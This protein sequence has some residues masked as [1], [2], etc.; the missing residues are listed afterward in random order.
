MS[1]ARPLVELW[2]CSSVIL[3]A[4]TNSGIF[5]TNQTG[6]VMCE[7]PEVEGAIIYAHDSWES[8][9]LFDLSECVD[10]DLA[11]K[12]ISS[13]FPCGSIAVDRSEP[14]SEAWIHVVVTDDATGD[15][16]PFR[17]MRCVLTYPNSD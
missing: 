6:G 1:E 11:E 4:K 8:L 2:S 12:A 13:R 3:I 15:F 5:Y 17:G 10:F 16:L 9:G 14:F 7:H